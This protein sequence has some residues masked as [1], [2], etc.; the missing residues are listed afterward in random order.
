MDAPF[1]KEAKLIYLDADYEIV[2]PGTFVRCAITGDPIPLDTL[3]YWSVD[4][5]EA[6][7]DAHIATK[8]MTGRSPK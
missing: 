2:T 6:Y 4:A 5:Q 7:R 1:A 8:A 3:R